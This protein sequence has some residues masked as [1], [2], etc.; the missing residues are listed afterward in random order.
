ML[1]KKKVFTLGG[2]GLVGSRFID[3]Y[4]DSFEFTSPTINELDIL[5]QEALK[6][7]VEDSGAKVLINFAAFT[8]VDKAEA[9]KGDKNGIVYKLNVLAAGQVA[10][11]CQNL[12]LRLI[13]I[14]TA[15]VFDGKKSDSPYKE[16]DK[17]NPINWYGF[18]KLEGE[19][20]VLKNSSNATVLRIDM[21]Y[22]SQYPEKKDFARFF[23]EEL[24]K[25][26]SIAAVGD[27]NITPVFIDNL[28]EVISG[29]VKK[30]LTGIFHVAPITST[31]PL[32]FVRKLAEIL[33]IEGVISSIDFAEFNKN[34]VA[35]RPQHTWMDSQKIRDELGEVTK[36]VGDN[37]SKLSKQLTG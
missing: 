8:N 25:S 22:R 9:E 10:K 27:Q 37:I 21:P 26:N 28:A 30:P 33:K 2:S 11:L 4:Q 7:A 24:K 35:S 6:Q 15:Y 29:V 5:D 3:L 20:E 31:T 1:D 13:H 36:S 12:N 23:Y 34:R 19:E 17:T 16:G 14:S 18:T 32:E